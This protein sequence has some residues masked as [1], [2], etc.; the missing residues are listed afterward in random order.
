MKKQTIELDEL[1]F[2]GKGRHK[3]TFIFPGDAAKCIKVAYN[4]NGD[5][6]EVDLLREIDYRALRDKQGKTSKMLPAYYGKVSTNKGDGYIFERVVDFDGRTTRTLE[7]YLEDEEL[8][9]K[10]AQI[11][12]E[13]LRE[14]KKLLFEE[15]LLTMGIFP[16]NVLLQRVDEDHYCPRMINDM[17]CANFIR[18]EYYF[19]YFA[20]KKIRRRWTRFYDYLMKKYTYAAARELL[21]KIGRD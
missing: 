6:G 19:D 2:I 16:E 9:Q 11:V 8:L 17:G 3:K 1:N 4:D 10:N 18:L 20:L 21:Q 14:F 13:A 12:F 5:D 7:E 15:R